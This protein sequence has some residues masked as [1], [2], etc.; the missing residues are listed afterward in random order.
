MQILNDLKVAAGL[1]ADMRKARKRGGAIKVEKKIQIPVIQSGGFYST[2][3]GCALSHCEKEIVNAAQR[4]FSRLS[5]SEKHRLTFSPKAGEF[6]ERAAFWKNLLKPTMPEQQY[7]KA[8]LTLIRQYIRIKRD[9]TV[10]S[11]LKSIEYP[12]YPD[13]PEN[14]VMS[15]CDNMHRALMEKL[16]DDLYVVWDYDR[17]AGNKAAHEPKPEKM[18]RKEQYFEETGALQSQIILDSRGNL[19]D[20]Y[21]SYL[22][23]RAHGI[24]CVPIRYG[25]RQI[26][27][28]S[29]KP[30]G[31]LYS[32]EL[33]GLL[34]DRV[35]AEDKVV[36]RTERGARTVIVTALEEYAGNEPEPLR[37]VIKVKRKG[38]VA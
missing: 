38:G 17:K 9:L 16:H 1:F 36:V 26:V 13:M 30:G 5:D 12:L 33:P 20:G 14:A 28:A 25:R 35:S 4:A 34:I 27:R 22:L 32:W 2:V 18:Q 6:A 15:K 31:K 29:H 7:R 8:I 10:I 24:Q 21:T 37:M 19:I 23:A 3:E 11:P